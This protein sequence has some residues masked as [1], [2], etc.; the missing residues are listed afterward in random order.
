MAFIITFLGKGGTGRTTA[1]IAIAQRLAAQGQRTLL[2]GQPVDP[3]IAAWVGEPIH[4]QPLSVAPNLFVVQPQLTTLLEQGW[5]TV[6]RLESEYLRTPAFNAIFAEELA[7]LPGMDSAL[8]MD[9]LRDYDA[10]NQY[11]CIVYDGTGDQA[12]LRMLGSPDALGWYL[13][14]FR[15]IFAESDLAKTLLP[16]L[17]PLIGTVF[18]VDW[19]SDS[20]AKPASQVNDLLDR[21]KAIISDPARMA[22]YLVTT[23]NAAAIT[24]A[25]YLWGSAQQAGLTVAGAIVTQVPPFTPVDSSSFAPLPMYTL[26][27]VTDNQWQAAMEAL[28][29]VTDTTHAPRSLEVNL[30]ERKVRLFLPGFDKKQVKLSQN[31][32][33]VTIAAGDQ[34]RNIV[35]PPE[36]RGKPVTGAKF[37]DGYLIISF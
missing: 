36:L 25:R 15:Q 29:D 24:M 22:A 27:W 28:P 31:G 3:V 6:K 7:V 10:S 12:M 9:A 23:G 37:Q 1:A 35:L 14:R 32:P 5:E 33:E 21:G 19:T 26:P 18:N 8:T 20:F 4:D 30:A 2:L 16:L 11:D 17:Q 13:R 34:R